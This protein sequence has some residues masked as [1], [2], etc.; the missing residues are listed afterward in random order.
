[1]A[2]SDNVIRAGLT[3]KLRDV[4]NLVAGL[5]YNAAD[6]ARHMVR[7]KP[8]PFSQTTT[9]STLYDPPIPEFSVLRVSLSSQAEEVHAPV[10]GPSIVVVTGGRGTASWGEESLSISEGEV[11]FVGAG[12]GVR[13]IAQDKETDLVLYRAYVTV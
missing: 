4:P 8:S 6:P 7:P 1:M 13:L 2:A 10:P 12:T 9:K 5:T 11:F 3:P